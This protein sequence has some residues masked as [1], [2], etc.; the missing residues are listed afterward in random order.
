MK[1]QAPVATGQ[2]PKLLQRVTELL[3]TRH[4]SY[5]TEKTYLGWIRRFILHFEKRH[6]LELGPSAIGDYLTYLAVQRKVSASTQNQ[7][8]NSLVFLYREVL[9]VELAEIP[10]I[11]WARARER[12]PVVFTREEVTDL[13]GSLR[14]TQRLLASLLYGSG[15]RLTECLRLRV[16]DLDFARGQIAI[17]DSKSNRDRSVMLPEPLQTP[18]K[19]HL[20]TIRAIFE[21]DRALKIPGVEMPHALERKYPNAGISW[22]WFWVFPSAKLSIDPRSGIQR[23]HHL[24][25]SIMQGALA[26]AMKR[27]GIIKHATCHT[28]R[29]S[30]ATHLLESGTD[31]R[32]IQTLLGHQDLKTTMIYT[33]VACRGHTATNS[34]LEA[35]WSE[36]T[37]TAAPI[38]SNVLSVESTLDGGACPQPASP[39]NRWWRSFQRWLLGK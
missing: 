35:V 9:G 12:V 27:L 25:H 38:P 8:L 36:V 6:P 24:H 21:E 34:P 13:L 18:L 26:S 30:F 10:G 5:S 14:Q 39:P 15:L 1:Q 20:D 4:Y 19:N 28:F 16:K 29:H 37:P 32:T 22:G 11:E 23:R 2:R 3:R 33:H 31:I 7:A 17:W